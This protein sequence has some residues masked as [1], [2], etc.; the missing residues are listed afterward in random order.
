MKCGTVH[1]WKR[2]QDPNGNFK[3]FGFCEFV[4]PDGTR[5]ALRVLK[6][7]PLGEKRLNVKVDD[8]TE[9]YLKEFAENQT[10]LLGMDSGTP[11]SINPEEDDKQ[12]RA[13][14]K[15]IIEK[16]APGILEVMPEDDAIG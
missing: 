12:L 6:D 1:T 3:A 14:I 15:A 11:K 7:Y 8:A 5:R 4:H 9:K 13:A 10:R 2:L 16:K